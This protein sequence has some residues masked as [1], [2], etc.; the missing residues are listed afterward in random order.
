MLEVVFKPRAEADLSAI[1]QYTKTE[2]GEQQAKHYLSDIRRQIS[3]AAEIPGLGSEGFGLPPG[4]RK[5]RVGSHR[6]IYRCT[7]DQ[8]VV[9]RVLHVREDVPDDWEEF[10]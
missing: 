7:A 5:L 9:V 6:V 8:L 2:W 1:A 10:W 4:Y 3:F